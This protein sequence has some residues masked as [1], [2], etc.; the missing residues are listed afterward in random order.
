[1]DDFLIRAEQV[2]AQVTADLAGLDM[3]CDE[4][5]EA[6]QVLQRLGWTGAAIP[7]AYGGRGAGTLARVVAIEEAT[8]VEPALGASLSAAALGTGLLADFGDES[9]RARWLPSLASGADVMTICMTEAESGSH[10]LGMD[11]RARRV[12][13]GWVITGRK[14]FIGN[15]HLATLHGVIARTSDVADSG[16]LSAFVVEANRDGCAVGIEHELAGLRGFNLGEVVFDECWV[17]DD[18]L[19]GH[20]GQGIALA[21]RVVTCHGKPNIGSVALGVAQASLDLAAR[22]AKDRQLYGRPLA[23]LETIRGRVADM[24]AEI[25]L[26]R[27]CLYHAAA[28]LDAGRNHDI[29]WLVGKLTASE[30]AVRSALATVEL[31]GAR[32]CDPLMGAVQLL[33]DALM[34][35]A[36][37][38]TADVNRKRLAEMALGIYTPV[39]DAVDLPVPA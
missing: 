33:N 25:Y 12:D 26:S 8:R 17:P 14:C 27:L 35:Q 15:S 23:R 36:P 11:T 2:R 31:M 10:L 9:Q 34:T 6:R 32:G 28:S 13:G 18:H 21:H 30:T 37:S 22:H 19:V 16:A 38:G 5:G 29:G 3:S 1:V 39:T 4:P 7:R 20:V 24:F